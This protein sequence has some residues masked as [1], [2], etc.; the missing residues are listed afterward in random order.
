MPNGI[1]LH[2]VKV[3]SVYLCT[4]KLPTL[5]SFPFPAHLTL[6]IYSNTG[7]DSLQNYDVYARARTTSAAIAIKQPSQRL[8]YTSVDLVLSGRVI[9]KLLNLSNTFT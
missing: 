4:E 1:D 2:G 5:G 7:A 6:A 9:G 8:I 3:S